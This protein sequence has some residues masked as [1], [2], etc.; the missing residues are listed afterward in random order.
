MKDKKFQIFAL[1]MVLAAAAVLKV[2][3]LAADVVPFNSDEA[4]VGLMARHILAGERPI[5][6]YGQAYMGSLDAWLVAAGFWVFG[7]QVWVIRLVQTL[8]YLCTIIT[9]FLLGKE[10]FSSFAS[11]WTA[12]L[13]L[14]IPTVNVTLYTTASL[15]GYG[16]ALVLGNL[17][18]WGTFRMLK[19]RKLSFGYLAGVSVLT[20]LGLW[21]N[22]LTL[23]YV[24]PAG[25]AI[26]WLFW[27]QKKELGW[28]RLAA[29]L[30]LGILGVVLGS[31]PWWG[32]A[33]MGDSSGLIHELFGSAIAVN[34]APLWS[35]ALE[36]FQSLV[37]LGGT[38]LMGFRP[39]WTVWW[40]ALPLIPFVLGVWG[41]SIWYFARLVWRPGE[42]RGY[43]LVLAGVVITLSAAFIFTPFG[44]D[45]SGRYF[46]PLAIPFALI[47]G[48]M[49]AS[50]FKKWIWKAGLVGLLVIFNLWGTV[51][52]A[53]AYPP[54]LTTQFYA[55][56]IVEQRQLPELAVFL[57]SQGEKTGYTNYW[58][59]YPLAFMS[60]ERLVYV[61]RLP[62]HTDLRYTPRDDRYLPYNQQ[63]RASL[64]AAYITTHNPNLD[65]KLRTGFK[66][67]GV[68]WQENKIGDFQIYYHLSRKVDPQ[69]LGLGIER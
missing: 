11:A 7:Q 42:K 31:S 63:V 61:P 27:Q 13:L 62:Y 17:I 18:L 53:T 28:G 52:C 9:T 26:L 25:L 39:P 56:T 16:E 23:V 65:E 46:L 32:Y 35:Q 12:A 54:G 67:L 8:L 64:Q 69:E 2:S 44:G 38:V 1:G 29:L 55:V 3:L 68:S 10:A 37:L 48:D 34:R 24:A 36:H 59:S 14:A 43:A 20:G 19:A 57:E 22:G 21:A 15:G 50:L 41:G 47:M 5:F 51:Q 66:Q 40:L 58:V 49:A 33:L 6:F 45:P 4:V 60:G 30:G